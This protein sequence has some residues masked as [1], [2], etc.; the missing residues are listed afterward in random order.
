[1]LILLAPMLLASC[2][3]KGGDTGGA[4]QGLIRSEHSR[5]AMRAHDNLNRSAR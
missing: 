4:A 3:A 5:D 2:V 1:V